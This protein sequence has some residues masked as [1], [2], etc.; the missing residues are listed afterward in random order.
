M[1]KLIVLILLLVG[2]TSVFAAS[3]FQWS[4]LSHARLNNFVKLTKLPTWQYLIG[5]YATGNT[6]QQ[7]TP[8]EPQTIQV[9]VIKEVQV[10]KEVLVE[11]IVEVEKPIPTGTIV[12]TPEQ[13]TNYRNACFSYRM[14]WDDQCV[15]RFLSVNWLR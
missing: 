6:I 5:V 2:T 3:S 14:G 8:A 4:R 12:F 15:I 10:I 1:R 9:E 7:Y 13:I 11:K